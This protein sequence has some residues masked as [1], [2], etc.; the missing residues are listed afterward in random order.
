M[1][2]YVSPSS[3]NPVADAIQNL[4]NSGY[5]TDS[6]GREFYFQASEDGKIVN[7]VYCDNGEVIEWG[8]PKVGSVTPANT[9]EVSFSC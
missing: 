4:D 9:L 1:T 7:Q 8:T 6:E 5:Q 3:K 2:T